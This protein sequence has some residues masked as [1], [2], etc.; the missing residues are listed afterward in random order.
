LCKIRRHEA[1]THTP[2]P[3]PVI[4]ETRHPESGA[5][6]TIPNLFY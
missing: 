2:A 1:Q 5:A 3:P 4:N 6:Y